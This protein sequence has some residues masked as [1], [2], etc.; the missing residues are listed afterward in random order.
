MS[1]RKIAVTGGGGFIGRRVIE[2]AQ[3]AG[4]MAWSFDRSDGNDVMR[5]LNDLKGAD[6]VIHLAGVLGTH[7]L[8]SDPEYAVDINVVGSLR[9]MQWCI[10]NGAQYT[11]ITMPDAFP[12]IYTATKIASQRLATALHHSRNLK[13]SHVR[14]F[15][16]F[17]PGQ[18]WGL[19]HPQ[20]IIPTFIMAALKGEPLPIWGDGTQ[21]VDLVYVDDVARILLEASTYQDNGVFDAGTGFSWTVNEVA[22]M[23]ETLTGAKYHRLHKAMRDGERPTRIVAKGDGWGRVKRPSEDA[24][25]D[26]M[27]ITIGWYR[28]NYL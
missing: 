26:Q 1:G 25:Q 3:A 2:L 12:S 18:K 11:G 27:A 13:C 23:I 14:A 15:N 10:D 28:E 9:V 16:A 17:G 24:I 8:F 22:D 21:G 6:T 5:S 4:D 19:D 20:K 7:E